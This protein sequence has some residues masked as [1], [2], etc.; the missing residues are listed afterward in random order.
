MATTERP[1]ERTFETLAEGEPR[2]LVEY[3]QDPDLDP[4]LLTFA[5]E[6]AGGIADSDLVVPALIGLLAHPKAYVR[7]GAVYGLGRHRED[8]RAAAALRL[9]SANDPARDVRESADDMLAR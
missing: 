9:V 8:P 2:R 6:I 5:A 7:E 3:L 4:T 1:C